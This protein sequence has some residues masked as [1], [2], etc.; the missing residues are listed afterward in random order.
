MILS[1]RTFLK[2]S[3]ALAG[4]TSLSAAA[5]PLLRAVLNEDNSYRAVYL[6]K[7][8]QTQLIELL[9]KQLHIYLDSDIHDRAID[10]VEMFDDEG[11]IYQQLAN[12]LA[13]SAINL[14][15][16]NMHRYQDQQVLLT[17]FLNDLTSKTP[18][19]GYVSF[20]LP[21]G[22]FDPISHVPKVNG[23][24]FT[25]TQTVP[26]LFT[27]LERA[28]FVGI[29]S[30]TEVSQDDIGIV[31]QHQTQFAALYDGPHNYSQ[32]EFSAL[33]QRLISTMPNNGYLAMRLFD[34]RQPIDNH[35]VSVFNDWSNLLSG[36]SWQEAKA[37]RARLQSIQA[38]HSEVAKFGFR[39][40]NTHSL[41][42]DS[43]LPEYLAIYEKV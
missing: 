3:L 43:V 40:K 9:A 38:W 6:N 26:T 4:V 30:P 42:P 7:Y 20:G 24:K 17:T 34:V 31:N 13:K 21:S 35:F 22:N 41:A 25:V 33:M 39:I 18:I 12:L 10:C 36:K 23:T 16:T 37:Q 14:N 8:R 1:R 5:S 32:K 27:P 15:L 2:S 28:D 11:V 29:S 19:D